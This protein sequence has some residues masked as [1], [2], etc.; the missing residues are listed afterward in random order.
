[1]DI[2]NNTTL[3]TGTGTAWD[4]G[5]FHFGEPVLLDLWNAAANDRIEIF[6]VLTKDGEHATTTNQDCGIK[7]ATDELL[8]GFKPLF[9]CVS[10]VKSAAQL[11][12]AIDTLVI[13][14]GSY[15]FRF[16]GTGFAAQTTVMTG[17]TTQRK[18]CDC[19][20]Q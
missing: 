17:F 1:M 16:S 7:P 20:C 4:T 2:I 14:A 13:P 6:R 18:P 3:M 9:Q 15:K 10:G 12:Q 11:T 19:D 5:I 8:R